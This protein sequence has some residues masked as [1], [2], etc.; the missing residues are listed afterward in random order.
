MGSCLH[1]EPCLA[2]HLPQLAL[3]LGPQIAEGQLG[4]AKP[5]SFDVAG[6]THIVWT[7]AISV[8]V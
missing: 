7:E 4:K 6:D 8:K 3:P 2:G 1:A 5:L